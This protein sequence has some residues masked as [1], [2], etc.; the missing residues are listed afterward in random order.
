MLKNYFLPFINEKIKTEIIDYNPEIHIYEGR[1]EKNFP[2]FCFL[3]IFFIHSI[4]VCLS[5]CFFS[6]IVAREKEKTKI[7]NLNHIASCKKKKKI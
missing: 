1:K 6:G 5:V 4:I 3:K 2:F 7:D